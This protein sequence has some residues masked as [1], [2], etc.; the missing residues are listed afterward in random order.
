MENAGNIDETSHR[1]GDEEY[2]VIISSLERLL[3][4]QGGWRAPNCLEDDCA[5][6][7]SPAEILGDPYSKKSP[8]PSIG[9]FLCLANSPKLS[10]YQVLGQ[11]RTQQRHTNRYN[12]PKI[13]AQ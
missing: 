9:G 7:H 6:V 2:T 12:H 3:C 10:S 4:L 13:E 8:L 5:A 11:S 1:V